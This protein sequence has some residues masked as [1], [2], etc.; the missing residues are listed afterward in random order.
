M[1]AGKQRSCPFCSIQ[2]YSILSCLSWQN[3]FSSILFSS[4]LCRYSF[5]F[6][7]ESCTCLYYVHDNLYLTCLRL[8]LYLF[9]R[10]MMILVCLLHF[11]CSFAFDLGLP[12]W[13]SSLVFFGLVFSSLLFSCTPFLFASPIRNPIPSSLHSIYSIVYPVLFH[14]ILVHCMFLFTIWFLS[15]IIALSNVYS[16]LVY[17][18]LK[19]VLTEC[20][21][22]YSTSRRFHLTTSRPSELTSY[23]ILYL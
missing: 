11:L 7:F 23:I 9:F 20:S 13:S 4:V 10:V 8:I 17:S 22:A 21:P 19:S 3:P 5:L 18:V 1:P 6:C 14:A 12:P 15:W 2:L 16:A